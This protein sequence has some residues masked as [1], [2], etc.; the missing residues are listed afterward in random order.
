MHHACQLFSPHENVRISSRDLGKRNEA[1]R[2]NL[3]AFEVLVGALLLIKVQHVAIFTK[4][5]GYVII[6]AFC[7]TKE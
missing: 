6:E 3:W 1:K 4:I 2:E 5:L 7:G